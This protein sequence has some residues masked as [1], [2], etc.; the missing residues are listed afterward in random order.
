MNKVDFDKMDP[1]LETGMFKVVVESGRTPQGTQYDNYVAY[2]KLTGVP[3]NRTHT[4]LEIIGW[5]YDYEDKFAK[6]RQQIKNA[7]ATDKQA[8]YIIEPPFFDAPG[9]NKVIH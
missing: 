3:E 2:N 8:N 9:Q 7:I 4:E 1:V 6:L 5:I